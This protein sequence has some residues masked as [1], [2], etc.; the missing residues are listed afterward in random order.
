MVVKGV[1]QEADNAYSIQRT[2]LCIGRVRFLTVGNIFWFCCLLLLLL[3]FSLWMC[4]FDSMVSS[5]YEVQSVAFSQFWNILLLFSDIML[6]IRSFFTVVDWCIIFYWTVLSFPFSEAGLCLL[7]LFLTNYFFLCFDQCHLH[8][9][10]PCLLLLKQKRK[11]G[12]IFSPTKD[13]AY[14]NQMHIKD[15]YLM[16]AESSLNDYNI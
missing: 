13:E 11:S 14:A 9:N 15:V 3:S 12:M 8:P 10:L 5:G 6:S 4:P 7:N 16:T 2:W 1:M